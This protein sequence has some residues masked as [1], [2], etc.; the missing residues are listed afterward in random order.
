MR[1]ALLSFYDFNEVRGG[2]ELFSNYLLSAFPE[3]EFVTFS[4]SKEHTFGPSLS[5][6]NLEHSRMAFA[7]ARRLQEISKEREIDV[8]LS[9]DIS[10]LGLKLMMPGLPSAMIFHY[11]Y[12]EMARQTLVGKRS[13]LPSRYLMPQI[14]SFAAMGKKIVAVS[15]KVQRAL[16]RY[17]KIDSKVIENGIPLDV[18]KP[19]D[20]MES[21][22]RI[23]IKWRGPLAIF[24]GRAESSKGFD[25][26]QAIAKRRKDLKV[27]CVTTSPIQTN[28]LIIAKGVKNTDMPIYY[29][30]ADFLLFPS[31]YESLSYTSIE[32]MACD[33]PVVASKTGV[34]ED[35]NEEDVGVLVSSFDPNDYSIAIDKVTS[36]DIH[37]R[38]LTKQRFSLDRFKADYIDLVKELATCS[39][40]K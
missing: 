17:Y 12:H 29:S 18:F 33:L 23:G 37:P 16:K 6:L 13:Y 11:T 28:D 22:E 32:A 25:I 26:V 20:M 14:E 40:R 3:A 31:R 21:R 39:S 27:L 1:V 36:L 8:A 5:R 4:K 30:A 2:T 38:Q 10:G 15:P 19:L 24:V 9:S 35:L 34:F 7:M